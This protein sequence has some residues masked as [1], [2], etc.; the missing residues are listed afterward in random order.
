MLID[1]SDQ[2]AIVTGAAHRVG[3]AIAIELARAVCI[4]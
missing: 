4:L 2:I 3:K 1:L